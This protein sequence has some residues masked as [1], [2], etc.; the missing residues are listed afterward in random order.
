[1][2]KGR[3]ARRRGKSKEK[4]RGRRRGGREIGT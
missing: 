2:R 3:W 1:M 4:E